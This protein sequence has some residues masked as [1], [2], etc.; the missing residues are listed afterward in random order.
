MSSIA[1]VSEA[2]EF[3]LVQRAK[4]LERATGFVQRS[5]VQLDGP[6]FSQTC[7]LTWMHNPSAGYSPLR[8]TAGSLGVSVS[9][10][11][12]EQR[13]SAASA[14]LLR[15]LVEEAVGQVISSEAAVPELLGRFNGV[16]L[17]DGTVLSLPKSFAPPWRGSGKVGQEAGL[18]IQV[19]WELG[20][21]QLH[22]LWLQEA[23]AAERSGPAITTPLPAGSLFNGD[24]GYFTLQEMRRRDQEG[25]YWLTH[26][27]ASLTL[28]DHHGQCWDLLSFLRAQKG[29]QVDVQVFVGKQERLPVRLIAVRV[30]AEVAK[31]RRQRANKQITPPP[32]GCQAR[33]V[34]S[35]KPKEQRRGKPKRKK[36]SRARLRLADWTILLTNV[37]QELLSVQ[38]ALV[39]V[40][41]RWQIELLWKLWKQD[42]KLDTWRSCNPDRVLT[43]FYAKLL[44]L[45]FTHWLTLLGC[46]QAPNRSLVKAKQ[47][48]SWMSPCFTLA[49]TGL[50]SVQIVVERTTQTMSCGCPI[51]SRKTRPNTY[52]LLQNPQLN[53]S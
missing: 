36:V 33:R 20:R 14:R 17:Q 50:I 10:Q 38:E 48:V 46:W 19:R 31:R 23:R 34:G 27:K 49:F 39:L 9:T 41:C 47:V 1:Q 18:R 12:V 29:K 4:A 3:I 44:G 32:K 26:A 37:P 6:V 15:A 21:G 42:G 25:Q 28:I 22:G 43:E 52:Q 30:S 24:M 16:Y 40:R 53:S 5:S 51:N 11:A 45:I 13:F 7:V 8:H 2:M 35:R